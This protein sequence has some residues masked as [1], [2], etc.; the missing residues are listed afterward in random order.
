M[1]RRRGLLES[2]RDRRALAAD[3]GFGSLSIGSVLAGVLVAYGAFAILVGIAAAVVDALNIDT[4]ITTDYERLGILGG[5]I[6]AGILLLSYLFGGYVAGR[7]A[8]RAGL[9]NGF[10]VAILGLAVAAGVAAIVR[11]TD[12]ATINS[13]LRSLGVPTTADEYGQ[14]F[15]VAGIASLA[16]I[17]LGSLVGGALGERWHG[18][19]LA[20]A[21]NPTIGTEAEARKR[22]QSDMAKAEEERTLAFDRARTTNPVRSRRVDRDAL[23]AADRRVLDDDAD[24]DRDRDRD[25]AA[26]RNGQ[27]VLIGRTAAGVDDNTVVSNRVVATDPVID[28]ADTGHRRFRRRQ[29]R[30]DAR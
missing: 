7:M 3:A 5:L 14:A 22:A 10:L 6:V 28:D 12:A 29:H 11:S 17:L 16:A 24:T 30:P 8:R 4:D 1:T 20:R 9:F 2:G 25:R 13:N 21:V 19:L 23:S 27:R 15:T 26:S 18:K